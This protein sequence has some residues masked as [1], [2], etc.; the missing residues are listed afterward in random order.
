MT[1][2]ELKTA[3]VIGATGL[4]GKSLV[5]QLA[6]SPLVHQVI[7]ISRRPIK[8]LSPKLKNEVIDFDH[9]EESAGLFKGDWLFSCLGTTIKKAGT[10]EAQRK[11]D[12]HYQLRAAELAARNGVSHY[13]LVST[14]MADAKSS[15]PYLKM[16]GEL[17]EAV[18][19]LPFARVSVFQPS[20]L[21]GERPELR[22]G[23]KMGEWIFPLFSWIPGLRQFR[24]IQGEQVARK[25][26]Q[27][28]QQAGPPREYFKL[29]QVFPE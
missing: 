5:D 22:V 2:S 6:Q 11:V 18:A 23:E 3:I 26:V 17:E 13:L 21:L 12:L 1:T 4:V 8:Y 9:L 29:D 16:K 14:A 27:V 20:L 19:R 28:S 25:M 7:A 10:I 15:N 24:P